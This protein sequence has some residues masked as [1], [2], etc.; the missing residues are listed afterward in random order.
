MGPGLRT[1]LEADLL[2][3]GLLSLQQEDV[4]SGHRNAQFDAAVISQACR[5]GRT[6][7]PH[8]KRN[9]HWHSEVLDWFAVHFKSVTAAPT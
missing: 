5:A 8:L 2:N 9:L 1:G 3:H 7:P 4:G 6:Q